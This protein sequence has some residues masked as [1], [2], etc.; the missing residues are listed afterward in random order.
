M[1]RGWIGNYC[2]VRSFVEGCGQRSNNVVCAKSQ[3]GIVCRFRATQHNYST[4]RAELSEV[5][6]MASPDT[7][8]P[9]H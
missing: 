6:Q 9:H 8:G 2:N 1:K 4:G 3:K 7:A 5:G